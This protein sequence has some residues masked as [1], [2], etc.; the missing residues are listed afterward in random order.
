M[1][2]LPLQTRR[3]LEDDGDVTES[4]TVECPRRQT[5]VDIGQCLICELTGGIFPA[6]H[7]R[8]AELIC[9]ARSGRRPHRDGVGERQVREVMT[10]AVAC[11]VPELDLES[12]E[13]LLL[14]MGI[15]GLPVVDEDGRPIG[16][17]AKADLVRAHHDQ[18][19]T[20]E[21]TPAERRRL[22]A[23]FHA[24]REHR[25]VREVM[26]PIAFT[27]LEE[28]S[29]SEAAALMVYEHVHHV[30]VV[31]EEGRVGRDPQR[32]RYRKDSGRSRRLSRRSEIL[33]VGNLPR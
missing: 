32:A 4:I 30:P 20:L 15:G 22:G 17:L 1:S 18:G 29:L 7:G 5:S 3:T 26:T 27:V 11:V 23:G 6:R 13:R 19:D 28:A 25:P 24:E 9:F 12:A 14:E 31:N 21:L 16:M 8:V 33:T 2:R 10:A